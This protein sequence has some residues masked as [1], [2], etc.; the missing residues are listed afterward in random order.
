M[1]SDE[2]ETKRNR[3]TAIKIASNNKKPISVF[4]EGNKKNMKIGERKL[5]QIDENE[6]EKLNAN[7]IHIDNGLKEVKKSDY[8]EELELTSGIRNNQ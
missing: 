4:L 1:R 8:L 5:K 6:T 3:K 7:K 2:F